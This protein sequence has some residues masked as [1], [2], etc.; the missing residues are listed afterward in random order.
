MFKGK[1]KTKNEFVTIDLF[2]DP[3]IFEEFKL[4]QAKNKLDESD[5]LTNVL[6]RGIANYWLLEYKQLKE[7][8]RL[9]K[10]L[11]YKYEKDNAIFKKLSQEN[12]KLKAILE[13]ADSSTE[14]ACPDVTSEGA[15]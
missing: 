14:T 3:E 2:L 13:K 5:A 15:A 10:R 12:E 6:Q 9:I 1:T 4:Y 8:Y 11:L 7:N